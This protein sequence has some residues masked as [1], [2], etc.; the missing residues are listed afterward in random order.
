M[1]VSPSHPII[2]AIRCDDALQFGMTI[3]MCANMSGLDVPLPTNSIFPTPKYPARAT[4]EDVLGFYAS[5][6][7]LRLG[8]EDLPLELPV[9]EGV[10]RCVHSVVAGLLL[11]G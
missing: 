3:I 4:R 5:E 1:P 10:E 6:P 8:P 9:S 7:L 2:N 11:G